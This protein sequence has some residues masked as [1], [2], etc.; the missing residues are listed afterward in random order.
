MRPLGASP[1]QTQLPLM[2]KPE[3][4]TSVFSEGDFDSLGILLRAVIDRM[5]REAL[6]LLVSLESGTQFPESEGL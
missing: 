4:S 6:W 1:F 5:D 3:I 2:P